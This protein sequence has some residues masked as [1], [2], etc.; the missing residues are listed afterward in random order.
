MIRKVCGRTE[1]TAPFSTIATAYD[2]AQSICCGLLV[3]MMPGAAQADTGVCVL[4]QAGASDVATFTISSRNQSQ[5]YDLVSTPT[6]T[7]SFVVSTNSVT[8]H[9]HKKE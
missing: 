3:V 9:P 4:P 5:S 7:D 6:V 8:G 2:V 1:R